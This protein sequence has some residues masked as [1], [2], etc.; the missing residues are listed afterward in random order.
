MDPYHGKVCSESRCC[1]A[2]YECYGNCGDYS[3]M[4]IFLAVVLA[5]VVGALAGGVPFAAQAA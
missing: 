5:L 2:E 1:V 4:Y 3:E